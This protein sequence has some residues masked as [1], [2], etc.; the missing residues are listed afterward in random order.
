MNITIENGFSQAMVNAYAGH[1]QPGPKTRTTYEWIIET[2]TNDEWE[3]V[4]EVHHFETAAEAEAFRDELDR[5]PERQQRHALGLARDV[6]STLDG[7][8][9]DRTHA[10][11]EAGVLPRRFD[12][13]TKVPERFYKELERL[14]RKNV[15][16]DDQ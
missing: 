1:S 16:G 10:Y 6:H 3:D 15:K 5:D 14:G 9:D 13:G 4:I 8:L 12:N 2:L 7:D 11:V